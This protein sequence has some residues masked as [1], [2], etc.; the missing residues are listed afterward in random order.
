MLMY[1]EMFYRENF[2]NLHIIVVG[3]ALSWDN[4]KVFL[5]HIDES[6]LLLYVAMCVRALVTI[7]SSLALSLSLSL[8]IRL[9]KFYT[10][11]AF[12]H[13][14]FNLQFIECFSVALHLFPFYIHVKVSLYICCCCCSPLYR[15]HWCYCPFYC[16]RSTYFASTQM[17]KLGGVFSPCAVW[18]RLVRIFPSSLFLL[19]HT[20]KMF[21]HFK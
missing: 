3:R 20:K 14:K 8:F 13:R 17:L 2:C 4:T 10:F 16:V 15:V 9:L 7:F 21:I 11:T 6:V 18:P 1:F 19:L 5:V 12:T